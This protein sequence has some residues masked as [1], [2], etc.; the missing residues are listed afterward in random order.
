MRNSRKRDGEREREV[1]QKLKE[2]MKTEKM[3]EKNEEIMTKNF[4]N[5]M[6]HIYLPVNSA[7]QTPRGQ[8]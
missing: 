2:M 8:I 6:K 7:Q 5:F 1:D 3:G 4:Q